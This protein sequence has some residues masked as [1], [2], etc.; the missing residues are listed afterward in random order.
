MKRLINLFFLFVL[1]IILNNC[2]INTFK[3]QKNDLFHSSD[4]LNKS[5][6]KKLFTHFPKKQPQ[7]FILSYYN[8]K[9]ELAD[10]CFGPINYVLASFYYSMEYDSL[11]GQF[12]SLQIKN[13]NPNDTS[14][15]LVFPYCDISVDMDGNIVKGLESKKK[16]KLSHHN[17]IIQ[18][19]I[20]IPLFKIDL[21]NGDTFSGLPEDFKIYVLEAKP[22]KYLEDKY[23]RNCE[24]LPKKWKHGF[25][26]GV[27]MSDKRHVII[28]W[29]TVW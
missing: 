1:V 10:S 23:L 18:N 9:V 28:Y 13:L 15:I 22:G 5:Y 21:Y 7:G 20:P 2:D 8:A 17:N 26:R 4:F 19:G 25:S 12:K 24:C 14:V 16:K 11:K 3:S 6:K 29:V 27:A